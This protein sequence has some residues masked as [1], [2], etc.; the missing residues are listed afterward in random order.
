MKLDRSLRLLI[1]ISTDFCL[2]RNAISQTEHK[3]QQAGAPVYMY[4]FSWKT[5]CFGRQ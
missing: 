1:A 2:W 3:V 4:E 5:P